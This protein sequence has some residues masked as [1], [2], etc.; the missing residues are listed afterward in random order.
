MNP[1]ASAFARL[2]NVFEGSATAVAGGWSGSDANLAFNDA[3]SAF[4]A[5][6]C[7]RS[8]PMIALNSATSPGCVAGGV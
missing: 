5:A 7:F 1:T 4:N 3:F 6:I 2:V 8:I